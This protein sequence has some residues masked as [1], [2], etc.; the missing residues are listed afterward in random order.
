MCLCIGVFVLSVVYDV[1]GERVCVCCVR[2]E[3]VRVCFIV[4]C[5]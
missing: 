2:R 3:S 4:C 1:I 5:V